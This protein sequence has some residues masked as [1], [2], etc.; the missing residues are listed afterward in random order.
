MITFKISIRTEK[1]LVS[2]RGTCENTQ[3]FIEILKKIESE[4][5]DY[6]ALHFFITRE[7]EI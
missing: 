5:K 7:K 1:G 2:K 6:I 3:D 4:H